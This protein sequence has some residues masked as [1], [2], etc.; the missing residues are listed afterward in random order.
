MQKGKG[1]QGERRVERGRGIDPPVIEDAYR[2]TVTRPGCGLRLFDDDEHVKTIDRVHVD[3]ARVHA[4]LLNARLQQLPVQTERHVCLLNKSIELVLSS[5]DRIAAVLLNK[6]MTLLVWLIK[7]LMV[8][9]VNYFMVN[10]DR[11][12]LQYCLYSELTAC[13][14]T[15]TQ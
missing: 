7:P 8:C 5:K 2:W 12:C 11:L 15:L 10:C 14:P 1:G 6:L 9:L 4:F 3:K 13:N